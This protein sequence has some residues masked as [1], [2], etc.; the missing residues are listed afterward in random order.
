MQNAEGIAIV[1]FCGM[2]IFWWIVVGIIAGI[3]AKALMPGNRKEPKGC[4]MTMALGIAGSVLVG[5]LMEAMGFQR[6]GGMLATIGGATIGACLLIFLFR[7]LW[8]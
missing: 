1:S 5:F 3:L 4:L 8:K 2:N 7:K 6:N